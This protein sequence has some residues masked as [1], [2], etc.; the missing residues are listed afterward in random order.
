MQDILQ[1][2]KK[3]NNKQGPHKNKSIF[4]IIQVIHLSILYR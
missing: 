3:E 2:E 1:E 4:A